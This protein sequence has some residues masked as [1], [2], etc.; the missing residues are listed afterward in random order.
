MAEQEPPDAPEE[1]TAEQVVEQIRQMKVSD[2]LLSTATTV[3]QLGYAKLDPSS[4]DL[5]QAQLAID[6]LQAL[7][8]VLRPHVPEEVT[9]DLSQVVANMQLAYA[10]A[11]VEARGSDPGPAEAD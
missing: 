2:L 8:G 1:L 5:G 10:S 7:I 11:A 9:R 6:A 3:A 4:R